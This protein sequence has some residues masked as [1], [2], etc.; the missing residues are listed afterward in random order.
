MAS[1]TG[2]A[3][4]DNPIQ[5]YASA[6]GPSNQQWN[7]NN[8]GNN[9]TTPTPIFIFRTSGFK[10]ITYTCTLPNGSSCKSTVTLTVK[11][12]P[13]VRIKLLSDSI[14]CFEGNVFCFQDSSLSGD[15]DYCIKSIKYLFSDNELITKYGTK[16][17]PVKLPATICKTFYDPQGSASSLLVEIEDCNGCITK[18]IYPQLLK[19]QF[20]PTL[21]ASFT[22]QGNPCLGF[23]TANFKNKS[24]VKLSD[25]KSFKWIFGDGTSDSL[26]WDSVKHDYTNSGQ[27]KSIYNP[28]LEIITK[29]GCKKIFQIDEVVLYNLKPSIKISRDSF[30]SGDTFTFKLL[31][32]GIENYVPLG[33]IAWNFNP[34]FQ[35]E[36][37]GTHGY[38]E[39]GPHLIVCTVSH[40]CG[41]YV[42][43]DTV[44][45]I[46]PISKI[47]KPFNFIEFGERYQCIIKD[48]V[49]FSDKSEFYHNDRNMLD[50]DSLF[51]K[52]AGNLGHVFKANKSLLNI[53]NIRSNQNVVR[54]WDF[55]DTYCEACTTD[56]K[57]NRNTWLN[58]RYSR[59]FAPS[60]WYTPWDSIYKY[61]Y[62][63][64]FFYKNM[65]DFKTKTC[66]KIK[67]F[68][69]DSLYIVTDTI[70]YYGDNSMGNR[71]KDSII[72]TGLRKQKIPSGLFGK[73]ETLT[74]HNLWIYVPNNDTIYLDKNDGSSQ[75]RVIGPKTQIAP[76][77]YSIISKSKT[78]KC[79][80]LYALKI[81]KDT[82]PLSGILGIHKIIKKIKTPNLTSIDTVNVAMHR[83]FFYNKIPACFIIRLIEKD[84][85][86]PLKCISES[87]SSIALQPPSAKGLYIEDHYCYGYNNKVIELS[88][89]DTKPGCTQSFAKINF[90]Y[91]KTPNDYKLIHD[92]FGGEV[93]RN[94]FTRRNGPYNG[95]NLEGAFNSVFFNSYHDTDFLEKNI[96]NVN[97]ALII[98][99]GTEPDNY[100][101]D[102][103]YY[104]SFAN[105]P[106]L[107]AN[108]ELLGREKNKS[109]YICPQTTVYAIIPQRENNSNKLAASSSWYLLNSAGDTLEMII[110]NYYKIQNHYKYPSQKVNYTVI[111]RYKNNNGNVVLN[112]TDTI[113]T[114]IVH[115]HR[116]HL[117]MGSRNNRLR[118]ELSKIGL[119]IADYDDTTIVD[120]IWNGVGV[121]GNPLSGSKGCIDTTGIG[122]TLFFDYDVTNAT[123]LHYKDSSLLPFDSISVNSNNYK[124]YGFYI[125]KRGL[126]RVVRNV[127]S[128]YPTF[129]PLAN[130]KSIIAGFNAEITFNDSII[131]KG[132]TID[133]STKFRYYDTRDS[134]FGSIDSIDYWKIRESKAGQ[135]GF[136]AQTVWDFSKADD[137]TANL[138]TIFGGMPYAR[139]GL[140]NP[141]ISLGKEAGGI[142]YKSSGLYQLRVTMGDSLGCRDTIPQNIYVMG[143]KAGFFLDFRAPNCKTIVELFDTSYIMDPCKIR[144]LPTCD[145]IINWTIRWG[146]GSPDASF[147]KQLPKQIGHDFTKNGTFKIWLI[148]TTILG[149][150]DSTFQEVDLPGPKPKFEINESHIICVNDSITFHNIS[151]NATPS[152]QW[153]WNYGDG[154]FEPQYDTGYITHQYRKTGVFFVY[155]TQ[156]DSIKGTGK[157]CSETFPDTL[158]K[159]KITVLPY[160]TYQLQAIPNIVCVGDT[161]KIVAI[162][163]STNTYSNYNWQFEKQTID[164]NNSL[165]KKYR[166]NRFGAFKI[167]FSAD[168]NGLNKLVCPSR[169]SI[170]VYTDSIIANFDIDESRA[171]IYC[172]N[173]TSSFG[174]KYRW[175]FFHNKDIVK[176][177]LAFFENAQQNEP[178]RKICESYFN[179]PGENWICLE[180]INALGCRDTIC[181]KIM[182]PYERAILP[183]NVFTPGARDGFVSRDKD[184]LEGNN[185]FNI[186]LKGEEKYDLKIYDRWGLLVFEST[187]KAYDW[188][189]MVRNVAEDCP[190]GTYYYI[191]N[192][193]YKGKDKDEPILNGVIQLIREQ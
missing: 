179:N 119:S 7:F 133:A 110:E 107:S 52:Q 66:S 191:L 23:A 96:Q 102:T 48:T 17:K 95:Y 9:N 109:K 147:N 29:I 81:N 30:C 14:Q 108:L 167:Y 125:K 76:N 84:T 24:Q 137:N 186:Y 165:E 157:Y 160:D 47:E 32:K 21:F 177:K 111:D 150:V 13:Q 50:D 189:G 101:V 156:N 53:P 18:Y 26:N 122:S 37:N 181:K 19:V 22:F 149:C 112:K 145:N 176:N 127:E 183:P 63:T 139:I 170:M 61:T 27:F 5:F 78:D 118:E 87:S 35:R 114:A 171:P 49:Y 4:I 185:Y 72:F 184:G 91:L 51:N 11:P 44:T 152:A 142:Y 138:Q 105:F 45:V 130:D 83:Q 174:V 6:Q 103:V 99:N 12:K 62:S 158:N 173:N 93:Y 73:G 20:S 132:N 69:S 187:D 90:N 59:E 126:Y 140:G 188:N 154:I 92:E 89:S 135:I 43:T 121:I 36:Y 106:R 104:P 143:P 79:Y 180:A 100:C 182:N 39:L 68:A 38:G 25:I 155:L 75:I 162:I 88:L 172:F 2:L 31:P 94:S 115:R 169:D 15:G 55:G 71:S 74:P 80:F 34:G 33:N 134:N 8:E 3:C 144:G 141:L 124:A 42:L 97:L 58:C 163:T 131:C 70:L 153:L 168:T 159:I 123:I 129:C 164:K 85:L 192:Y 56:I 16:F 65:F 77:L 166:L 116:K 82:I 120:L 46:G 175:G 60:H 10:T 54:L 28:R 57:A 136:E 178:D 113:F 161:L 86:H 98:G 1:Y 190:D 128:I 151:K 64:Q 148:V 67:I 41:P 117:L 146:D 40:P 193:R